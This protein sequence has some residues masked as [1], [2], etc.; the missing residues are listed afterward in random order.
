M[1]AYSFW[2]TIL[3]T[4]SDSNPLS[5]LTLSSLERKMRRGDIHFLVWDLKLQH[6]MGQE[7]RFAQGATMT[8]G[9]NQCMIEAV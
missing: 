4:L 5:Y 8:K 3:T 9:L 7:G 2:S 6:Q 1:N